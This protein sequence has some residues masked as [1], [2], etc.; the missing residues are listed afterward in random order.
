MT[1][2]TGTRSLTSSTLGGEVRVG[3]YV[4]RST[5]DENQPYSKEAQHKQLRDYI[6]S[7][8]GWRLVAQFDDWTVPDLVDTRS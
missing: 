4:R 1:R 3:I 5:N 2:K 8:P 6:A 7:Q